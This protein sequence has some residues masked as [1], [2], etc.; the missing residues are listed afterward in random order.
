MRA[1]VLSVSLPA[2]CVLSWSSNESQTDFRHARGRLATECWL[3]NAL[4]L[5]CFP[6]PL[7]QYTQAYKHTITA[8]AHRRR[9][10]QDHTG[11]TTNDGKFDEPWGWYAAWQPVTPSNSWRRGGLNLGGRGKGTDEQVMHSPTGV[12]YLSRLSLCHSDLGQ[13][14][15]W[16]S[17]N[18]TL[19]IQHDTLSC[20]GSRRQW[21]RWHHWQLL[22]RTVVFLLF[23]SQLQKPGT[24]I[25]E[26]A[27]A[28]LR[29]SSNP[30]ESKERLQLTL[31]E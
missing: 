6:A 18:I 28:W 7:P 22:V 14:E 2:I 10:K 12:S 9:R 25:C 23:S 26:T 21:V 19:W 5:H 4:T 8:H 15:Q 17:R 29:R 20:S 27:G 31:S 11:R 24:T 30:E 13:Q 1:S 3:H 16:G